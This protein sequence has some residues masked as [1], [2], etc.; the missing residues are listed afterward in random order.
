MCSD[1]EVG[2]YHHRI[3]EVDWKCIVDCLCTKNAW[4]AIEGCVSL[5]SSALCASYKLCDMVCP[6]CVVALLERPDL[7]SYGKVHVCKCC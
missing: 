4:C 6:S 3:T 2:K 7:W 1:S 5:G